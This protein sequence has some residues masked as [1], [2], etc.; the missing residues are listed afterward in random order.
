VHVLD[1]IL[2]D[3]RTPTGGYAHSAGLE[4]LIAAGA[5]AADVPGFAIARLRTV[6][7]VEAAFAAR[8][9]ALERVEDLLALDAELAARTPAPPLREV[10]RGLGRALLHAALGWWPEDAVLR[11]YRERSRF[12]PR[13]VVL[14]AV[15]RRGGGAPPA[16]AR[17]SLYEDAATVCSAAV[18]LLPLDPVGASRWLLELAGEI[19]DL[20]DRA[21]AAAWAGEL[22]STS[23]P[24]LDRDALVHTASPRR[25]FA[26]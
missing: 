22:P 15:V 4:R 20:A 26:S 17:L 9:C 19:D 14:G 5:G 7:F 6:A 18:K 13:P 16:A 24:S 1:L 12:S 25:L 10:S 21:A 11:G 2:A 3:G 23:T 8:A